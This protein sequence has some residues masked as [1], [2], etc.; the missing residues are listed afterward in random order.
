MRRKR[1]NADMSRKQKKQFAVVRLMLAGLMGIGLC[2][3]RRSADRN[4]TDES[5]PPTAQATRSTLTITVSGYGQIESKHSLKIIPEIQSRAVVSYLVEDGKRVTNGE[6]VAR[7]TSEELNKRIET[8][9]SQIDD[10]TGTLDAKRTELDVERI[11]NATKL[12][13][14]ALDRRKAEQELEQFLE[15]DRPLR[16]RNASL[17]VKEAEGNLTR[18]RKR[19]EDLKSLLKEGFITEDEVEEQRLNIEV[20]E[21]NL[22]TAKIELRILE[23]Y[24][25]PLDLAFAESGA[26]IARTELDKTRKVNDMNLRARERAVNT[27]SQVLARV[28]FDLQRARR[29]RVAFV[30][31][32]PAEG[33]VQYGD[34]V[35][36]W[37]RTEIQVGMTINRGQVLMNI[38]L[39][40]DLK[41]T[42]NIPEV[43]I[44]L[45]S[46]GQI[47]RITVDAMRGRTFEG[48][49][50]N[51]AEVANAGHW[52]S[53][54]VKEFKVN[55][56]IESDPGQKPGF[57]CRAEIV[58]AVIPAA[59]LV[60]V[61]AVFRDDGG[62]HVFQVKGRSY[63]RQ[64]VRLGGASET[65]VQ[66]L[67]GLEE[68]D[69]VYLG[70]PQEESS[71]P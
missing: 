22:E 17:R 61:Q 5:K 52:I 2:S 42:I 27:A 60:P 15:G 64:P 11:D 1:L 9:E 16:R 21:I 44:R 14:A 55:L 40:T 19:Y 3:C 20:H 30:I 67:E 32:A 48:R 43:D 24:N 66:I 47:A 62:G 33:V 18:G 13:K 71:A 4:M 41:A 54:D 45:V 26:E 63:A 12:K 53:T 38:P 56:E 39:V 28:E 68:G 57:S 31:R 7:L 46:T 37:R 49:V 6:V 70:M 23:L 10:K 25:L 34:A 58:T 65:H 69:T 35:R 50:I 29:E 36:P 59:V 51:V 8:L